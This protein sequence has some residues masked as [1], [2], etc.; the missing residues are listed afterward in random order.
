VSVEYGHPDPRP[1]WVNETLLRALEDEA[2]DAYDFELLDPLDA[3]VASARGLLTQGVTF[4]P[5]RY[6]V[7]VA[8]RRVEGGKTWEIR[9]VYMGSKD[10]LVVTLNLLVGA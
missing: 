5:G 4:T 7:A 6:C 8:V 2:E 10:T 9:P 1:V 3:V